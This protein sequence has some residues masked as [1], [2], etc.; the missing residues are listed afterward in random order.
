MGRGPATTKQE[1]KKYKIIIIIADEVQSLYAARE[2]ANHLI[3]LIK[4]Q[5]NY[6]VLSVTREWGGKSRN[7]KLQ[8]GFI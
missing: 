5:P 8:K 1:R 3:F 6:P 7:K 2:D 4:T